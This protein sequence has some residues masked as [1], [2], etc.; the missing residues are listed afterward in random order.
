VFRQFN[1]GLAY[2]IFPSVYGT[3]AAAPGGIE[4]FRAAYREHVPVLEQL[5]AAGW[6]PVPYA[7]A[8]NG[9]VV[10]RFGSYEGGNLHFTLRNYT[11]APVETLLALDRDGLGVPEC[12]NLCAAAILPAASAHVTVSNDPL[13]IAIAAEG[14]VVVWV[15]TVD[16]ASQRAFRLAEMTLQRVERTFGDELDATKRG[17]SAQWSQARELVEQGRQAM[18]GSGSALARRFD[19]AVRNL[20]RDFKTSAPVDLAKLLA[21]ARVEASSAASAAVGVESRTPRGPIRATPGQTLSIPWRIRAGAIPIEIESARV[22][23]PWP[24]VPIVVELPSP[25]TALAP[26]ERLDAVAKLPIPEV[27]P[28]QLIPVELVLDGR[29][30]EQPFRISTIIDVVIPNSAVSAPSPQSPTDQSAER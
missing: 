22:L 7:R 21:R 2:G 29:A 24:Q 3:Q 19:N 30:A 20:E 12:A 25:P 13:P 14:T 17:L 28:R 15:G 11:P 10:E 1:R 18:A 6:E 26:R 27:A 5:S 8:T 23:T 9:V 4:P 16:Q